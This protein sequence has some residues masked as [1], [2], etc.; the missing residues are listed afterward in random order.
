MDLVDLVINRLKRI[1]EEIETRNGKVVL[2]NDVATTVYGIIKPMEENRLLVTHENI[3][4]IVYQLSR[5][6]GVMLH[7]GD[8]HRSLKTLGIAVINPV[9]M[10]LFIIELPRSQIDK[11]IVDKENILVDS[12]GALRIPTL[13]YLIAKMLSL[14]RYPYT[15]YGYTLLISHLEIIDTT[16][17][18]KALK[19]AG[20][21]NISQSIE[22]FVEIAGI[23][24]ELGTKSKLIR[25]FIEELGI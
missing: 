23:F 19:Q 13:E 1:T 25:R 5:I 8:I 16:K 3:D 22:K 6:L 7:S 15:L 20:I 12:I 11:E 2:L 21:K 17:L 4:E 10:P 9:T 24:P 14:G 18:R